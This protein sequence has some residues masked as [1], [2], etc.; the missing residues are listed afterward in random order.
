MRKRGP[1]ARTFG[2]IGLIGPKGGEQRHA[3]HEAP[4]L[5]QASL[6][7]TGSTGGSVKRDVDSG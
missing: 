7:A 2:K 4:H 5:S 3:M 1:L 6:K